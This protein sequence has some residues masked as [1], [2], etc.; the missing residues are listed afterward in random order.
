MIKLCNKCGK[1]GVFYKDASKPD[2]LNIYCKIC[3]D[4]RSKERWET[5]KNNGQCPKCRSNKI[6][7]GCKMCRNCLDKALAR[8]EKR[9]SDGLCIGGCGKE[10]L[11]RSH[12][13]LDCT[14]RSLWRSSQSWARKSGHK[15][16][17]MPVDD[18]VIW[19]REHSKSTVCEWCGGPFAKRGPIADHDHET[20]ELRG[21]V[22]HGC[23]ILEGFGLDRLEQMVEILRRLKKKRLAA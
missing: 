10:P 8:H 11:E 17:V 23:N 19:Y 14:A 5:L 16:I 15:P 3:I 4:K 7:E 6:V 20:G 22:C 9:K 13:C 18:F 21:L 12:K 1:T 2:G